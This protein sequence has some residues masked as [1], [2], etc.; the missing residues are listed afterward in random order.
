MQESRFIGFG[1]LMQSAEFCAHSVQWFA[2]IEIIVN[3][4]GD[5]TLTSG[6]EFRL[7]FQIQ[8]IK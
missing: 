1:N 5:V 6:R 2:N 8:K 3:W 4:N 7:G